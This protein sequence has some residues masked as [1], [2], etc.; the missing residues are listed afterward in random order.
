[1]SFV[2]EWYTI[3]II[4]NTNGQ[5]IFN[6][7]VSI[8]GT[9]VSEIYDVNNIG[10][11]IF[12]NNNLA[13]ADNLFSSF[14]P[15]MDLY[16]YLYSFTTEGVNITTLPYLNDGA[17]YYRIYQNLYSYEMTGTPTESYLKIDSLDS[18][19]NILNTIGN[20][21]TE[22]SMVS[23]F[24]G[25]KAPCFKEDTKI[26]T[27]KGYIPIQDLKIGDLVKT[28]KHGY[29]P[30]VMIGKKE[31]YHPASPIRI[32]D[33]LYICSPSEYQEVFEDLIITGCHSILVDDLTNKKKEEIRNVNGDVYIT[34][35]KYRL[36]SCVDEKA[37]VYK[38][39][40]NYMVYHIALENDDY[41]SNYGIYANGLLIETCSKRFLKELS[42]MELM[43]QSPYLRN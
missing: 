26:L 34:E 2:K 37:S 21:T 40:G 42:K 13:G 32:K 18:N 1:M 43:Y 17:S 22:I 24:F 38:V 8:V 20:E 27:E 25:F 7:Y 6:G 30:I 12:A 14:N 4:N 33:Q 9:I 28:L 36:P 16:H 41:Y 15:N 10:V 29:L 35:G 23:A 31:I 19:G 5:Q 3:S 11:N 39:E